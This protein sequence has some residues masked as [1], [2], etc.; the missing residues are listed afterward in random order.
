MSHPR[1]HS[2]AC[3]FCGREQAVELW[4]SIDVEARPELREALLAGRINRVACAGCRKPFR[5]DKSLVYHD[6]E[7]DIFVHYDPLVAGRALPDAERSFREAMAELNR[8]LPPDVPAPEAHLVVEWSELIERIFL[9]EEGLDA[10]LVEHIKY[11]MFQQNP[12]K[13]PADKK[14]LLFDA[15]DSTDEQLCF[16]VQDRTT[17]KLEAVLNFARADYEALVNVFDSDEQLALL[18]EQFPGPYLS[19]RLRYLQDEAEE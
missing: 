16:V 14:N 8:L 18:E 7:Q 6:R 1:T 11:M 2:I 12:D 17:K 5:I 19:G 9:L 10:R 13:I 3:P 15:Q 4:D